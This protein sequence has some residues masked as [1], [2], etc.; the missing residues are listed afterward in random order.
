MGEVPLYRWVDL[1]SFD[2]ATFH[3]LDNN[4]VSMITDY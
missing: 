3:D 4:G 2:A 1:S